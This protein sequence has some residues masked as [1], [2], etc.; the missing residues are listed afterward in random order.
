MPANELPDVLRV[1]EIA[2][3]RYRVNHPAEDP[4]NRNVVFSGQIMAQMIMACEHA[5]GGSKEVKSIH[6][7]FA[8]A[9]RYTEPMELQR[10]TLHS[11][12]A[13]GSETLTAW[14]GERLLSRG[15]VLLNADEPD[16]MRHAA[17]MPDVP[18]PEGLAPDSGDFAY[19]DTEVRFVDDP[20]AT[21]P[22]GSPALSFWVRHAR[23]YASVAARQA[24]LVWCE[25]GLLIALSMRPHADTVR[26]EEAH[27]SVSTG[28]I[29]HTAHFHERFDVGEWL[30]IH[31]Q[32]SY[33][34][35]GR[36]NGHGSVFSRDGRLVASF[37]QDSMVRGMTQPL[38]PKRSM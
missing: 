30:L 4:E 18:G 24:S 15:L 5:T 29:A 2:E 6:A 9:G 28:V 32:S 14:Q 33:A 12:R 38:D 31:Q 17:A 37:E 23:S 20:E 36:V 7:I 8:R 13:W 35:R 22:D 3:G 34:G 10:E 25:P 27:H 16:L 19:A 11:G 1:E 26:P 21:A